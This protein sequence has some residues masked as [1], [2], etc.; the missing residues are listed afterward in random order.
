MSLDDGALDTLR[1]IKYDIIVDEISKSESIREMKFMHLKELF[2]TIG[3]IPPEIITEFMLEYSD[4]P[5]MMKKE[6]M[7]RLDHYKEYIAKKAQMQEEEKMQKSVMD[8][9][10]RKELKEA[11]EVEENLKDQSKAVQKQQG[12]IEQQLNET[13][14]M[15][16]KLEEANT[17]VE[18]E[19]II[20]SA[21]TRPEISNY[22]TASLINSLK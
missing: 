6:I 16:K 5:E 12:K 20:E 4:L 9:L 15:R 11:A 2:Q 3:T 10:K 7:S 19:K 8:S 13:E 21:N 1:E 18:R 14:R 17:Q 22:T